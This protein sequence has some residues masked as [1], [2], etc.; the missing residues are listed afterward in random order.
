MGLQLLLREDLSL[1][2]ARF[3]LK[4]LPLLVLQP[5]LLGIS[6]R[7]RN[8]TGWASVRTRPYPRRLLSLTVGVWCL[9]P[10]C[11]LVG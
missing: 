2:L 6:P 11:V 10:M 4:T 9:M 7:R 5:S 8:P 1:T 3:S